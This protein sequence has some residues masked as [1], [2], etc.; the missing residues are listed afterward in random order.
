M[1]RKVSRTSTSPDRR[2]GGHLPPDRHYSISEN[3]PATERTITK[4]RR[5][6]VV[7]EDPS[8]RRSD[9][10]IDRLSP[11]KTVCWQCEKQDPTPLLPPNHLEI[12]S[13]IAS[14]K[15]QSESPKNAPQEFT[16][17]TPL[18]KFRREFALE[19]K[20]HNCLRR[21]VD[22]GLSGCSR[23][24]RSHCRTSRGANRCTLA[25]AGKRA[26]HHPK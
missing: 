11:S 26:N 23:A 7:V 6:T 5:R 22:F 25:T 9:P 2:R 3:A 12:V 4:G 19:T 1:I 18:R 24:T 16:N 10:K 15:A 21:D 14:P 8:G 17:T 13:M 20:N